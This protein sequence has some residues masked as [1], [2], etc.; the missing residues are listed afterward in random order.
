MELGARV[1]FDT[2]RKSC[3]CFHT[4]NDVT[5]I[6]S[7]QVG[8]RRGSCAFPRSGSFMMQPIFLNFNSSAQRSHSIV[9]QVKVSILCPFIFI[10]SKT[11]RHFTQA[12]ILHLLVVYFEK[13]T[14]SNFSDSKFASKVHL[15]DC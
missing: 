3:S 9:S 6:A 1:D 12:C 4:S 14:F 10:K 8:P 11:L 13:S 5:G 2:R 15:R 7:L